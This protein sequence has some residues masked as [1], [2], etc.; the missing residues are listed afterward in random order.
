MKKILFL[1]FI[2]F[3]MIL[4]ASAVNATPP[5]ENYQLVYTD[6][7]NGDALNT[8]DWAYRTS[9]KTGGVNR[10]ENVRVKDGML[11]IDY[12]K[13]ND[14]YYGGGVISKFSMGYGYYETRAKTFGGTG[15]LHTSFWMHGFSESNEKPENIP[16]KSNTVEIDGFEINSHTPSDISIGSYYNWAD[17]KS[18]E[19]RFHYDEVIDSS[20]DYFIMGFEWLPDRINYYINGVLVGTHDDFGV[21]GPSF[22]WLTALAQPEKREHLIDDSK[23]PGYSEFDYMRYYQMPLKGVNI[24]GNGHFE[25]D[26]R[27][28]GKTPRCF[29][30]KGD[31]EA[32]RTCSNYG[33]YEGL[34]CMIQGSELPFDTFMGHE[35]K[36]LLPGK[37]TFS[38]M[39]KTEDVPEKARL[40]VYDE[41]GDVIAQKS[42]P[43]LADWTE[44]AITDIEID[45]YAFVAIESASETGGKALLA[46]NVTFYI[47]DGITY[48][49]TATPD[50]TRYNYGDAKVSNKFYSKGIMGFDKATSVV[51][52]WIKSSLSDNSY[53][54]YYDENN[55]V[56]WEYKVTDAGNY[57]LEVY[58]LS[59]SGNM[60]FQKYTVW[61]NDV[62]TENFM[63]YTKEVENGWA[64][65]GNLDLAANDVVRIKLS[66]GS[67]KGFIRLENI[68]LVPSNVSRMYYTPLFMLDDM[69]MCYKGKVHF[70][71]KINKNLKV[72]EQDGEYYIPCTLLD[73]WYEVKITLPED[74]EY[75]SVSE[76]EKQTGWKANWYKQYLYFS[77]DELPLEQDSL[78]YLVSDF[79][80]GLS[81][82]NKTSA[83]LSSDVLADETY[84]YDFSQVIKTGEWKKSSV[85]GGNYY[86]SADEKLLW[87]EMAPEAGVYNLQFRSPAH[88]NST[89]KT[90]LNVY[91]DD[92]CRTFYIDQKN[93]ASGWYDIGTYELDVNEPISLVMGRE[94]SSAM[95]FGDI[96]F[97]RLQPGVSVSQQDKQVLVTISDFAENQT[98]KLFLAEYDNDFL[99]D[100]QT[101][102]A[103]KSHTFTLKN[104]NNDYKI[105]LWKDG[106]IMPLCNT[107][108]K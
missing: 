73:E 103:S 27:N 52:E 16:Q 104:A 55:A 35:I 47:Q 5:N 95:R 6:E 29:V 44:V 87:L 49:E 23:L 40:V 42:I 77:P 94:L 56:E 21:Y 12:T 45:G 88:Q 4:G 75:I 70:A 54:A 64:V 74:A 92:V 14:T 106:K 30:V 107:V 90:F 63:L 91:A 19:P 62:E 65:A 24:L 7:F 82:T 58:R 34:Q 86:T 101:V 20:A 66:S 79:L 39:F 60:E 89:S 8:N 84:D 93:G 13:E 50:Y 10:P 36:H 76:I 57:N 9:T 33:A 32:T 38:G 59:H 2:L 69:R 71:D 99:S 48:E 53:F 97:V 100:V 43:E 1:M 3:G 81:A 37:Y 31:V 98:G 72:Y 85:S 67:P 11:Y 61:V 18:K 108:S 78:A 68:N 96:R 28:A 51:G 15:A 25:Y 22:M 46:D 105:L 17:G 83:E 26:I 41:E 102:P 80:L